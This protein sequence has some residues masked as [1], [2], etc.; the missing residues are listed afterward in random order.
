MSVT[1]SAP[2]L[3]PN[4]ASSAPPSRSQAIRDWLHCW[5]QVLIGELLHFLAGNRYSRNRPTTR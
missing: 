5:H 4:A 2:A 3:E 1:G